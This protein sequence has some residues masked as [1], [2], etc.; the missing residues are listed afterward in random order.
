MS[1][2]S[3]DRD[4]RL[5]LM[6]NPAV[7]K[8]HSAGTDVAGMHKYFRVRLASFGKQTQLSHQYCKISA[9]RVKGVSDRYT[10]NS[11]ILVLTVSLLTVAEHILASLSSN[12]SI[13]LFFASGVGGW[14]VD[15][16]DLVSAIGRSTTP[17]ISDLM[18][19]Y[20]SCAALQK[21]FISL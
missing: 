13:L 1:A 7:E 11:S 3:G 5:Q 4:A 17:S 18:A 2:V 9:F 14:V 10:S 19:S 12:V 15:E 16:S 8:V 20:D 6:T 21:N